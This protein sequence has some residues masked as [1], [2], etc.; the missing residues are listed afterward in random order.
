MKRRSG[1]LVTSL[2]AMVA[3]AC[4]STAESATPN[5]PQPAATGS[6]PA[7]VQP[8]GAACPAGPGVQ[9]A[10]AETPN[11][12]A[13]QFTTTGDV[14]GL[15]ARVHR[16]AEMHNRMMGSGM[17][18]QGGMMGS[19][20]GMHGG[21]MGSGGGMQGDMMGSG[22]MHGGM[23]GSGMMMPMIP[24]RAS[25]D[26]IP[27]G[28]RLVLTPTDPSQLGA[29]RDHAHRMAAMMQQGRCPVMEPPAPTGPSE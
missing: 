25:V 21:M 28:A 13:L 26:D 6:A 8:R 1:F 24:S 16:M 19:G 5:R 12:V 17:G 3:A 20:G 4:G 10:T 18:M 2:F 23:M 29:L 9:I 22:G 14:A 7:P 15:R 11:G 27:D